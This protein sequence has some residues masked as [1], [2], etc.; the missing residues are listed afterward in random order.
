[1]PVLTHPFCLARSG[2]GGEH[3]LLVLFDEPYRRPHRCSDTPICF[4]ADIT[5]A[6]ELAQCIPSALLYTCPGAGRGPRVGRPHGTPTVAQRSLYD[7]DRRVQ[8]DATSSDAHGPERILEDLVGILSAALV[9]E[10]TGAAHELP[11]GIADRPSLHAALC[12]L[13]SV[14][15]PRRISVATASQHAVCRVRSVAAFILNGGDCRRRS[16]RGPRRCGEA[17]GVPFVG[18]S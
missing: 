11:C 10:A 15:R 16:G 4:E 3:Q 13:P 12:S 1:V 8:R 2:H 5:A 18:T 17:R 9:R 6:S 7:P 14:S